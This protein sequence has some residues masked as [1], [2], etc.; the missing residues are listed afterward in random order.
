M[1]NDAYVNLCLLT[2][3]YMQTMYITSI[4]RRRHTVSWHLPRTSYDT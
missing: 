1:I 3:A 4:V 2:C